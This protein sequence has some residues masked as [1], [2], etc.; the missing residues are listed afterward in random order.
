[1]LYD[2]KV[3]SILKHQLIGIHVNR[4]LEYGPIILQSIIMLLISIHATCIYGNGQNLFDFHSTR[5]TAY[6]LENGMG[7]PPYA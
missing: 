4:G 3:A 6:C 5:T 7:I 1:M 2:K